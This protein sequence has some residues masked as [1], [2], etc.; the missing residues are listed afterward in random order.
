M[1]IDYSK[2]ASDWEASCVGSAMFFKT[3][4]GG[5]WLIQFRSPSVC[6]QPVIF[7]FSGGGLGYGSGVSTTEDLVSTNPQ[8]DD[9]V[10]FVKLECLNKFSLHDLQG[11]LGRLSV[12][13]IYV[14]GLGGSVVIIS[15]SGELIG[16]EYFNSQNIWS[17]GMSSDMLKKQSCQED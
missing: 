10:G 9:T 7:T 16:K 2:R 4:G 12:G 15:A 6:P 1:S 14:L 5:V 3:Y 8:A 11:A 17:S 13:E